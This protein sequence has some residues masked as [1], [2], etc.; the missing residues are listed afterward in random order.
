[1][2]RGVIDKAA[3]A[4]V[5]A[6]A[7]LQGT[8]A[9]AFAADAD[10]LT[11]PGESDVGKA[12]RG[13]KLSSESQSRPL[14][15]IRIVGLRSISE[16]ELWRLY[17]GKP[18]NPTAENAAA[19]LRHI[20]KLGVFDTIDID[21]DMSGDGSVVEFRLR[22][23]PTLQRVTINGLGETSRKELLRALFAEPPSGDIDGCPVGPPRRWIAR[24]RDGDVEPGMLWK[25]LPGALERVVDF[26][27]DEG[28]EMSSVRGALTPDGTLTLDVDEGKLAAIELH[29]VGK[30]LDAGVR[31][32]LGLMPG[33]V[34]V[35]ADLERGIKR[36]REEYPFLRKEEADHWTRARPE[37]VVEAE[38]AE[39]IRFH[40]QE[41]SCDAGNA[42][43]FA[44]PRP[45]CQHPSSYYSIDGRR[46]DV[47]LKP[48][49]GRSALYL[50]ETDLL[51]HTRV[52]GY[53]PGISFETH[54]WDPH[55]RAHF[56]L[57]TGFNWNT[58]RRSRK[59]PQAGFFESLSAKERIDWHVG[60]RLEVP[61]LRIVEAG[62]Q[63]H[64]FTD[65][66]DY[67]R[68]APLDVYLSSLFGA[69]SGVDFY[70]RAGFSSFVTWRVAER[71][72][73]GVEYRLDRYDSLASLGGQVENPAVDVGRMGSLV[74]RTEWSSEPEARGIANP[75]RNPET[76][77]FGRRLFGRPSAALHT[78]F[79]TMNTLESARPSLGGDARFDFTRFVSDNLLILAAGEDH[80]LL[81]RLRAAG[82]KDLPLQKQEALGGWSA[83]RGFDFKEFRGD[84][85]LLAMAEY[86][87][88]WVSAFA[89]LGSV[90]QGS[91]WLAAKL[92]LGVAL[93]AGDWAQ[94]AFAWRTDDRSQGSPKIRL[95]FRRSF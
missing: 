54:V 92:G 17:G 68:R 78:G 80:G 41:A 82:G 11:L 76:G 30:D 39:G 58:G 9:L 32:R 53:S 84:Y 26:L 36:V 87:F 69:G 16:N 75:W 29:G 63:L 73:A 65:S 42:S 1:M 66:S 15:D 37:L 52:T 6:W 13:I 64:A 34:F 8:P 38:T 56:A 83:L 25:G 94:L 90:K 95:I 44:S 79:R 88:D 4:G 67:W 49:R 60:P 7:L 27:F 35:I 40:T 10:C 61:S 18:M 50:S 91:S 86:R 24:V 57:D 85:S 19:L 55:H 2:R 51:R 71:L 70:R 74:F 5:L 72:T 43:S 28:H 46:L 45:G 21:V 33:D 89:D 77:L 48:V 12:L 14:R 22:E 93:N 31:K 3:S 23:Q 47:Y 62:V 59:A 81:L 20:T